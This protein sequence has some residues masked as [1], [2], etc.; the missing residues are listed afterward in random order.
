VT[1]RFNPKMASIAATAALG[2]ALTLV[3]TPT[4]SASAPDSTAPGAKQSATETARANAAVL[5]ADRAQTVARKVGAKRTAGVWYDSRRERMV[6]NVTTA[7]A[8]REVRLD[9]LTARMVDHST[10]ELRAVTRTLDD[11]VSTAG[12]AWA[13]DPAADEVVV[14]LYST[15]GDKASARLTRLSSSFGDLA[16]VERIKG[17]LST[18]ASGGDAIYGGGYRCSL[19]F[20]V[21][22]GGT[23]YFL[24]A[25]HCGNVASTWYADSGQSSVLGNT[26]ASSFPG[27]DYSIAQYATS[28]GGGDVDLYNGSS[29]DITTAGDAYV[30]QSVNRSGST[31][32]VHG[33]TVQELDATVN[34]SEGTVYGLIGTNVCA[35][36]GDSGGSL[37]AGST[38]LGLTSG[39]SGDCTSGGVTYFQ[40]VTE[41][42]SVYGVSV[43]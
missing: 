15:V 13:I 1:T 42:L 19:G 11:Q 23:Y 26:A 28:P 27:D 37:F 5:K 6:V 14:S 34:Y 4:S 38:A 7:K 9:G 12:T 16:R 35:E 41:P 32:G 24:T 2:T 3:G 40:P 43:Y 10:A 36:G 39:G 29:Q 20:N 25:G 30:G 33:G 31:T 18:T 8:A 17:Q 21:V 22:S